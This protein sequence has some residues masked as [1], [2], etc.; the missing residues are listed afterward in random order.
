MP[1]YTNMGVWAPFTDM[2]A[3]QMPRLCHVINRGQDGNI[4]YSEIVAVM[5]MSETQISITQDL[6]AKTIW[7][8]VRRLVSGCGLV[9]GDSPVCIVRID[10]TGNMIDNAPNAPD[11]LTIEG[12]SNGRFRLR[13]RYT[14]DE[15]EVTPTG[16]KIFMDS[17]SGFDF[18]SPPEDTVSYGFGGTGEFE[19]TSDPLTHG[20][21]YRFCVRTYATG[22]GQTQNTDYVSGTADDEGPPA[23]TDLQAS[24]QEF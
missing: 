13:W 4:D 10:A 14:K 24:F 8:Y 21:V 2:G 12:L 7:H 15:E 11:D 9:S 16:F 19:W 23:M 22:A 6:P 1:G 20:Q 3:Y 17:G 5:G 18:E